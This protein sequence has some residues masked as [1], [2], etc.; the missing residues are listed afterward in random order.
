MESRQG[1]EHEENLE[2]LP[3]NA[4]E[5]PL[6][7]GGYDEDPEAAAL[8]D[9][10]QAPDESTNPGGGALP[11]AEGDEAGLESPAEPEPQAE[12]ETEPETEP[13]AEAELEPEAAQTEADA[14]ESAE[15][16]TDE[17]ARLREEAARLH[18][19]AL[20]RQAAAAELREEAARL[21]EEAA[22]LREQ[23]PALLEEAARLR[24]EATAAHGDEGLDPSADEQSALA[25]E[26]EEDAPLEDAAEPENSR[27]LFRRR[28]RRA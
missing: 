26:L 23:S 1:N 22:A 6:E 14:G 11:A 15:S 12:P 21:R 2:D 5:E 10:P 25:P 18:E 9:E 20:A 7:G 28:R 19:A 3:E 8:T 24:E 13:Q 4:G 16:L 27:S 17:P